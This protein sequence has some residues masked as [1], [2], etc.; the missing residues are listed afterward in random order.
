M[1][2]LEAGAGSGDHRG[3]ERVNS[4]VLA[5][6]CPLILTASWRRG[7]GW[8]NRLQNQPQRDGEMGLGV[9]ICRAG[10]RSGLLCLEGGWEAEAAQGL[11]ALWEVESCVRFL[12]ASLLFAG[13]FWMS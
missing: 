6:G 12:K 5:P 2:S 8:W 10:G 11:G 9:C 1:P 7:R 3:L 13:R 4:P